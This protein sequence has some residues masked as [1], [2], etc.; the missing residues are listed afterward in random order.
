MLE[1]GAHGVHLR[2]TGAAVAAAAMDLLQNRRGGAESQPRPA[3]LFRDENRQIA[4]ARQPRD[5]LGRIGAL[6]IQLPPVRARKRSAEFSDTLADL[7][8]P[9]IRISHAAKRKLAFLIKNA[10]RRILQ[11]CADV[12]AMRSPPAARLVLPR[13]R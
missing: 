8:E 5:E 12:R 11:T 2:V 13:N 10:A 4:L 1:Q 3:V 6:A 9:F 7:R